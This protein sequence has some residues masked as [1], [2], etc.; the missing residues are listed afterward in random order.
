[1]STFLLEVHPSLGLSSAVYHGLVRAH[2]ELCQLHG[3]AGATE[4]LALQQRLLRRALQ[5]WR[6]REAPGA[7]YS[8]QMQKDVGGVPLPEESNWNP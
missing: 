5:R 6:R 3:A 8:P 4:T 2:S 1:M 7:A